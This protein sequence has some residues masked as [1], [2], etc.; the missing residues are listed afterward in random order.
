MAKIEQ[1]QKELRCPSCNAK[2]EVINV[3]SE[4]YQKAT[5]DDNGRIEEYGT[6]EE[7]LETIGIECS[8][9]GQ[10]IVTLIKEG[11]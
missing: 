1:A 4:C 11:D 10:S 9:C 7:I 6:I 8:Q 2:L 3:Y 5:V